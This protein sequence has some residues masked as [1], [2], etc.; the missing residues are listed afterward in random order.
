MNKLT[1]AA[2]ILLG[3]GYTVFGLNFF[4]Q[5]FPLPPSSEAMGQVTGAIYQTGYLFQFIK[6][7]EIVCGLLLLSGLFVPLALVILAPVTLNIV[8]MHAFLDPAG[9]GA[10]VALMALHL[11]LGFSNLKHYRPLLVARTNDSSL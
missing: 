3:L 2:R 9:L 5:F 11:F 10:G 4:F 8:L 1:L 7:T 6:L